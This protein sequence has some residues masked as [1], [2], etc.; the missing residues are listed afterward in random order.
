MT[1][2]NSWTLKSLNITEEGEY[3][4]L[5]AVF[6]S[7]EHEQRITQLIPSACS[8]FEYANRLQS[9]A[10]LTRSEFAP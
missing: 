4:H 10:S 7:G 1:K 5:V 9:K 8:P 3:L 2:T 6:V